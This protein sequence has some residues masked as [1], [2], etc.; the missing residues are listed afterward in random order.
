MNLPI[1]VVPAAPAK[2]NQ[3]CCIRIVK[4][5]YPNFR[6]FWAS[7]VVK[8]KRSVVRPESFATITCVA[9]CK[10]QKDGP[11]AAL[12]PALAAVDLALRDAGHQHVVTLASFFASDW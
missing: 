11:N 1:S 12:V 5:F 10:A 7:I 4:W 2:H 3:P 9:S 6:D 8:L